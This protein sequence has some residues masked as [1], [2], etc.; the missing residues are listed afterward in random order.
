[1]KRILLHLFTSVVISTA[2]SGQSGLK[3]DFSADTLQEGWQQSSAYS[4]TLRDSLLEV[5]I[6]KSLWEGIMFGF[7]QL[8]LSDHPYLSMDLRASEDCSVQI[9]IYDSTGLRNPVSR[10]VPAA[11]SMAGFV[12]DF[13]GMLES[14]QW[15]NRY[16]GEVDYGKI[17]SVLFNVNPGGAYQG[18]LEVDNLA[19]GDS[20]LVPSFIPGTGPYLD[21]VQILIH[22][23][24]IASLDLDPTGDW[25]VHGDFIDGAGHLYDYIQLHYRGASNLLGLINSGSP[26]RN[27]KVKV[28]KDDM[29]RERREWNLNY[30]MHARQ[31]LA[32][33]LF[34][35]AGVPCIST[36]HVNLLLNGE[37]HGLYL[38]YEDP[39]NKPWLEDSFGDDSGDLFKAA[40]D[41]PGETSYF[42]E[43]TYLGPESTDYFNHFR[44][45][46]NH[47]VAPED[48]TSVR[49]LVIHINFTPNEV[50][51]DSLER[52]FDTDAFI[53]YLVVSNFISNWDGYPHRG[54]NYW[55][56]QDASR[57]NMFSFIPWDLDATFGIQIHDWNQMGT[58]ADLFYQFDRTDWA[59]HNPAERADRPLVRR[60]MRFAQYRNAY[61]NRYKEALSTILMKEK[62]FADLDSLDRLVRQ[63]SRSYEYQVFH[64]SITTTK[65]FV[66]QRTAFAGAVLDTLILM[67]TVE[68]THPVD[69][70]PQLTSEKETNVPGG[71]MVLGNP[72]P[73]PTDGSFVVSVGLNTPDRIHLALYDMQGRVVALLFEGELDQG[74]HLF[75]AHPENVAPGIYYLGMVSPTGRAHRK[76]MICGSNER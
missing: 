46:T 33:H 11:E 12:F 30:S 48:Y 67:D 36:R 49:D 17:V 39:D 28:D 42:A 57:D 56:Y 14:Y 1:M 3:L 76:I 69:P 51:M 19:F 71:G 8:D 68:V 2:L 53:S 64:N 24:S 23:D 18:V 10:Y 52:H 61:I 25:D 72:W 7:S 75:Q 65:V 45:K 21:T 16:L 38:E 44:K 20:A 22:P 15:D 5:D 32:Y 74:S 29:Y 70:Y 60:M 58:Y 59:G 34:A 40:L 50:F 35:Q 63:N 43:L 26:Q 9:W 6:Q 55:L 62:L 13:T 31:E 54:K 27:W 4:L 41:I 47:N 37:S 66:H 73:N